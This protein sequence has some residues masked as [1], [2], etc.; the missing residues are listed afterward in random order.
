MDTRHRTKENKT[1]VIKMSYMDTTKTQFLVQKS[2]IIM[3]LGQFFSDGIRLLF[4]FKTYLQGKKLTPV[5][6]QTHVDRIKCNK[7]NASRMHYFNRHMY[8][9]SQKCLQHLFKRFLQGNQSFNYVISNPMTIIIDIKL[10]YTYQC[11]CFR[12][13]YHYYIIF[14][15]GQRP[16]ICNNK[17]IV[18]ALQ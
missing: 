8:L 16:H 12:M 15:D 18:Q 14:F 13:N 3:S 9:F 2:S 4:L 1:K 11:S 17:M 5:N 7:V 6:Y 10:Y